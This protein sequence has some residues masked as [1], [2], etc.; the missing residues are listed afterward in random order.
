MARPG[1]TLNRK[2][3]R[4]SR[5]LDAAV[6]PGFGLILARG[7]LEALWEP[8]YETGDPYIGDPMDVEARVGWSGA[9]GAL[10]TALLAAGGPEHAGFIEEGGSPWWPDGKRGMFRIHDLLDHMPEYVFG[11]RAYEQERRK[12]KI[13]DHCG[14]E[15]R[16]KSKAS[17]YCS[18]AC[19]TAAH[20]ERATEGDGEERNSCVTEPNGDAPPAP[21]LAPAPAQAPAPA[22]L[23]SRRQEET[24]LGPLTAEFRAKLEAGLGHGLAVAAQANRE[25]VAEELETVLT[26]LGYSPCWASSA[27]TS[28]SRRRTARRRPSRSPWAGS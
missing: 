28:S 12:G 1:L 8:S 27:P 18:N 5:A 14:A 20:R 26:V 2:F 22:R 9:E 23:Q 15:Y 24:P 16:S 7:V 11:R 25:R 21:A 3:K 13:C 4:L 6:A 10:C 19:R 17:K